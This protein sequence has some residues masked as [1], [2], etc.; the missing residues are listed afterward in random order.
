MLDAP[1]AEI[2]SAIDYGRLLDCIAQ[3]EGRPWNSLGG[4]LGF[5][6]A[7]WHEDSS[8]YPYSRAG[9]PAVARI[10]GLK[11]LTRMSRLLTKAG[12][13]PSVQNLAQVWRSGLTGVVSGH[14]KEPGYG[15]RVS[16]LY[17]DHR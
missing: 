9:V 2:Q 11:R 14:P 8:G 10:V 7:A 16:N 5:T 4:A 13:A 6:Y 15:V 17:Y 1:P 3:V 12:F